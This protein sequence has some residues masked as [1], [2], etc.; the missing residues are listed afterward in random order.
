[1]P[2]G[3]GGGNSF[4]ER[5]TTTTTTTKSEPW[6]QQKPFL[7]KGFQSAENEVLNRPLQ[8]APFDTFVGA[9]PQTQAA[10][11]MMENR[12]LYG[13]PL[14][15]AAQQQTYDTLQG[16]YLSNPNMGQIT[17]AVTAA[18]KPQVDASFIGAG[19]G[20]SSPLHTEAMARGVSRGI[21][22]FAFD[23]YRAGRTEM[24]RASAMAPSLANQ[25]YYD[26]SQLAAAGL[27]QEDY[28]GR[29]LADRLARH[30]FAQTE[31]YAR[32]G[33][34]MG[35]VGNNYGGTSSGT[36]TGTAFLPAGAGFNPLLG[37]LGAASSLASIGG[38]LFG[39][40]GIFA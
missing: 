8:F 26:I 18:V 33:Q 13:S 31:P 14:T 32:L 36:T 11:G 9:S 20:V 16:D 40:G 23:D 2:G 39:A 1:M 7:E 6:E 24:E 38:N 28:Q 27:G 35:L 4:Q 12:A 29:A 21:A 30:D 22:P 10:L 37:G 5:P 25:D 17:D 34:Y 19:R 3:G 15:G